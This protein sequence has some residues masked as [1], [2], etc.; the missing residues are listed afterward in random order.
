MRCIFRQSSWNHLISSLCVCTS[1]HLL[2]PLTYCRMRMNVNEKYIIHIPTKP[3]K[4]VVAVPGCLTPA[5]RSKER[6]SS[7]TIYYQIYWFFPI[8]G[9]GGDVC[10]Y[11]VPR[12]FFFTQL[13]QDISSNS[14]AWLG[15]PLFF[16][17]LFKRDALEWQRGRNDNARKWRYC[18]EAKG[19]NKKTSPLLLSKYDLWLSC[20]ITCNDF[21]CW[22][23]VR[24]TARDPE[25]LKWNPEQTAMQINYFTATHCAS[26]HSTRDFSL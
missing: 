10:N 21:A 13:I 26:R 1:H 15:Q 7:P 12:I 2:M 16:H 14:K 24:T 9:F 20:K 18:R 4:S 25:V 22:S 11:L 3:S 8:L 6:Q 19:K 23:W 5:H 17:V